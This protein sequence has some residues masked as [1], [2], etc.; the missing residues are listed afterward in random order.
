MHF[1]TSSTNKAS[2][3]RSM[4][5]M[6]AVL[7]IMGILS[8]G[9]LS[10]VN[11]VKDKN[12]A[13][14][15]LKEA[16]TQASEIQTTHRI[17]TKTENPLEILYAYESSSE[18]IKSWSFQNA[19][20]K[21]VILRAFNVSSGVC[22][23]L[24]AAAPSNKAFKCIGS[25]KHES[26]VESCEDLGICED[27]NDLVFITEARIRGSGGEQINPCENV[28]CKTEKTG[29]V[30]SGGVCI[31]PVG[32]A[33]NEDGKCVDCAP[34][35][36]SCNVDDSW[37]TKGCQIWK[38]H[39]CTPDDCNLKTGSCCPNEEKYFSEIEDCC[40]PERFAK[41][42][43]SK[44]LCCPENNIG[45]S[46]GTCCIKT[47]FAAEENNG[48]GKCCPAGTIV[49]A[50]GKCV[51][52]NGLQQWDENKKACVCIQLAKGAD[53]TTCEC[54]EGYDIVDGKCVLECPSAVGMTGMRNQE[55]K[56]LCDTT[57]G[58][59]EVSVDNSWC[60]CDNS[61]YYW[62]KPDGS[63][64]TCVQTTKEWA[65]TVYGDGS[66]PGKRGFYPYDSESVNE[67]VWYCNMYRLSPTF[68][69]WNPSTRS[70]C[71][72]QQV[73]VKNGDSF[74][75]SQACGSGGQR[76]RS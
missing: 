70:Y 56:C 47:Q 17:K 55:G 54:P 12:L 2:T 15:I 31:C 62:N 59:Q 50:A 37:D 14:Q 44:A 35:K 72:N 71:P 25:A 29:K 16:L 22:Q 45:M 1:K 75:C 13:N 5:E 28:D 74:A 61:R 27:G 7:G 20:K 58:Y 26:A 18:Y 63:C 64:L 65:R 40:P 38:H 57:A 3:G 36:R 42:E 76:S 19:S 24:T 73:L 66:Q 69:I 43:D 53:P 34:P 9:A 33:E 4:I 11:Y 68:Q 49:S 8:L 51:C 46:D 10:G 60:N 48:S 52:P 23:K 21:E 6:I 41:K 39:D 32:T 30:C 67:D